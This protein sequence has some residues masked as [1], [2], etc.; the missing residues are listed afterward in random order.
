MPGTIQVDSI[1]ILYCMTNDKAC[2]ENLYLYQVP[3]GDRIS[4]FE[5][6]N[7]II[8]EEILSSIR[9]QITKEVQKHKKL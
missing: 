8:V 3:H 5:V 9:D 6:Y 4:L 1:V 7:N 2:A